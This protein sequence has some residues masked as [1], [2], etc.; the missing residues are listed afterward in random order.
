[1]CPDSRAGNLQKDL[2]V[3]VFHV[4][5]VNRKVEAWPSHGLG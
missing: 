4:S 2:E 1:M 5:M 3:H